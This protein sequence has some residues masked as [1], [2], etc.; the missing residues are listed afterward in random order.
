[1]ANKKEDKNSLRFG[2]LNKIATRMQANTD[3]IYKSAY[4]SDPTNKKQLQALK[5][6]I[7][8]SIKTILNKNTDNIGEPN[9]SR[10]YE[11]LFMNKQNDPSTVRQF[12]EIFGDNEFMTSLTNSY[13]DNRYIRAQDEEIDDIIRYMP[14][15]QEALETL[16]D[17]VLSADSFSKDFLNITDVLNDD[18]DQEVFANNVE[19]MKKSHDLLNLINKV[20]LNE[21]KYGEEFIYVVPYQKAIEQ[22]MNNPNPSAPRNDNML[23][24]SNY[25]E[26]AVEIVTDGRVVK[27]RIPF[28]ESTTISASKS[29]KEEDFSVNVE[30]DKSGMI[31]SLVEQEFSA[32]KKLQKLNESSLNEQFFNEFTFDRLDNAEIEYKGS[33]PVHRKYDKTLDD[34]LEVSSI[35]DTTADGLISKQTSTNVKLKEMTG[36]LVKRLKRERVTP[37][38]VNDICLGYY[39]FEFDENANIFE[40]R[41]TT[42]GMTNTITGLRSN[43]RSEAL[44]ASQRREELVRFLAAQIAGKIDAEFV[45]TNQDLKKEI[46][47]ILKYNNDYGS[48]VAATNNIRVTYIPPEDIHHLYFELNE[49]TKRGI[50]D[51]ALALVPAKLWTSIYITNCLGVM[52][53]SND[54]RV[55]YVRQSVE[56][57]ISK[58]LLKTI[59]EIKK[60]N[61][62]IRQIENINNVLNITGR[63]NDYIIPRGADGQS[64]IDFE[65]MQGQQIEIKTELLNLLEESAINSTGVPIEL[66]QNRQSPDYALQ[67]TM[68]NSKFLRYVYSRQ[69]VFQDQLT[70]L[71]THIY[72]IEFGNR[73]QVKVTLPPPLFINITN[74]NQLVTNTVEYANSIAGIVMAQEQD[75]TIRN[76]FARE[77]TLYNLGSYVNMSVVD[78]LIEKA[79]H[80]AEL[81]KIQTNDM[82]EES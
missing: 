53:R 37:I 81:L 63:F 52:T 42:S 74:T 46:Y 57:N 51:L 4:L 68:Q 65:V 64:P 12:Q 20:Y 40:D 24:R 50:S 7:D 71:V 30:F 72:N 61:F 47:Y 26:S 13:L 48:T 15:L 32:R 69:S 3:S 23:I 21:A 17:N 31:T 28:S 55:Y 49:E 76:I 60:S 8:S 36:C 6:D 19:T 75:E 78:G 1:M 58:T 25:N 5:T 10:M 44:D 18:T 77:F 14:K 39:Y 54:K 27:E 59:D 9:I 38:Y 43:G 22:L 62:G 34:D 80:Q 67:L 70:K 29:S 66:I 56:K 11:R 79:R 35:E 82:G 16:R 2:A 41:Y 73:D 45:N 33:L